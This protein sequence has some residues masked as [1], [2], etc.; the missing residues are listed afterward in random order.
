MFSDRASYEFHTFTQQG[1]LNNP[2]VVLQRRCDIV[3][4]FARHLPEAV[5]THT[6][7]QRDHNLPGFGASSRVAFGSD[8]K[9]MSYA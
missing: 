4:G 3:P 8:T 9:T 2:P 7:T 5:S 1:R 6:D